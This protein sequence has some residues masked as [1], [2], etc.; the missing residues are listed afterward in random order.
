MAGKEIMLIH[1][2]NPLSSSISFNSVLEDRDETLT[3]LHAL[4]AH[5][6]CHDHIVKCKERT[7]P[8]KRFHFLNI[9]AGACDLPVSKRLDQVLTRNAV[10]FIIASVSLLTKCLVESLSGQW[11]EIKSEF[12][13]TSSSVVKCTPSESSRFVRL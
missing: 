10:G 7:V 3:R 2:V 9:Q 6:R 8:R 4:P 12:L 11:R 1:S 5:M 13:N